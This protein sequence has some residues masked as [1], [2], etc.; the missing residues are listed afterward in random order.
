MRYAIIFPFLIL[1]LV[2]RFFYFFGSLTTYKDGQKISFLTRITEEPQEKYGH[3][4]FRIRVGD[5]DKITVITGLKP[6]LQY[7]D[8]IKLNG[9]ISQKEHKG[10]V[11][12]SI[13]NP[14]IQINHTDQ[15]FISGTATGIR[16]FATNFYQQN[17]PPVSAS[18]LSGIVFGGNQG[19]PDKFMQ[20]LRSSGVVH[21]IAASGMN[22]T[23]VAG[24]LIGILGA[25]FKRQIALTIAIFGILFYAFIAGFEPSIV[26]AAVMAILAFSASLFGRQDLSIVTIFIT[27]YAMLLFSPNLASDVGFQLSF[28]ATLGILVIKPL[29]D[30]G[31][32]RVGILGKLLGQDFTTTVAAQAATMP[33]I[34]SVFGS[35]GILSVL[36]NVLVLW[37]VPILM[38]FGSLALFF[39]AIFAPLGKIFLFL[40]EPILFFFEKTVTYFGRLGWTI[41]VPSVSVF[42]WIGYYLWLLSIIFLNHQKRVKKSLSSQK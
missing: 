4:Q 36:V 19:L 2:L 39:G 14:S 11:F 17:L 27:G 22:V 28:L 33:V 21:V 42:V 26:R 6:T 8:R 9:T 30:N 15:N 32:A 7:G 40:A 12:S 23:F 1:A 5:G 10:H 37:T 34:L 29:L 18:L 25:I 3:Q 20:D 31:L 13:K 35:L 41:T 38:I 24:A 16:R